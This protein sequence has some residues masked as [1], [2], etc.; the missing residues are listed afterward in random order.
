MPSKFMAT[1]VTGGDFEFWLGYSANFACHGSGT[2]PHGECTSGPNA[3]DA[4]YSWVL[5]KMKIKVA[6]NGIQ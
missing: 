6:S 4:G 5:Q 2:R 3:P 1:T